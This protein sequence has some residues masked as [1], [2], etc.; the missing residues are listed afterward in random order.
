VDLYLLSLISWNRVL[1]KLVVVQ[2]VKKAPSSYKTRKFVTL[3]KT[4][5]NYD[6]PWSTPYLFL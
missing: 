2:P 3:F 4:A 5:Y 1:Q 6:L